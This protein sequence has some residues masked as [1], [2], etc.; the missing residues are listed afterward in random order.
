MATYDK[1]LFAKNLML[2]LIH[3][4]TLLM[5]LKMKKLVDPVTA[6]AFR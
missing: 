4:T 2:N 5:Q 6:A 1:N 3:L